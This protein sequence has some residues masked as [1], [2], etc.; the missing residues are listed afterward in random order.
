MILI[1]AVHVNEGG[2]LVLLK[3]LMSVLQSN[4]V[5]CYFLLDNRVQEIFQDKI[6]KNNY[7]FISTKLYEKYKFYSKVIKE[8]KITSV[9]CFGSA[10]PPILNINLP[11]YVYFH[12]PYLIEFPH[13]ISLISK[14][15]YVLKNIYLNIFGANVKCWIVQNKR[16]KEKFHKKYIKGKK[17]WGDLIILPFYP[18]I[19]DNKVN[20]KREKNSFIYVSTY[21]PHKNHEKLIDAFCRAYDKKK[22]GTLTLTIPE[23][24]TKIIQLIKNKVDLGYPIKNIGFIE[25][26]DLCQYYKASEYLIFPSTDETFGLGLIEA[27]SF[28]CKVIASNLDYVYEVCCPSFSFN[29]YDSQCIEKVLIEALDCKEHIPSEPII[30]NQINDLLDVLKNSI[31]SINGV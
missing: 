23:K 12:N 18:E 6:K 26:D 11:I 25:R 27:I 8:D 4:N 21:Y 29:P 15:K 30:Q 3:Y 13:S 14:L 19:K 24:H 20:V 9:L 16:M 28:G 31:C 2:S 10:P 7:K 17:N 22:K 1:D 5:D